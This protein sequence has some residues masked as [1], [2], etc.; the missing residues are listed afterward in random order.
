MNSCALQVTNYVTESPE[1]LLFCGEQC[2]QFHNL[3]E[4]N[5]GKLALV[6]G[7]GTPVNRFSMWILPFLPLFWNCSVQIFSPGG[8]TR[9]SLVSWTGISFQWYKVERISCLLQLQR[10]RASTRFGCQWLLDLFEKLCENTLFRGMK[11]IWLPFLVH[12]YTFTYTSV[13]L[14]RT[15]KKKLLLFSKECSLSTNYFFNYFYFKN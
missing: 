7:A 10:N 2:N 11:H 3:M 4:N 6:S 15:T 1:S 8:E 14:T 12:I 9:W 5:L 13:C